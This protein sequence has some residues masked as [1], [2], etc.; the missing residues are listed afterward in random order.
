MLKEEDRNLNQHLKAHGGEPDPE[1]KKRV[2]GVYSDLIM[3]HVVNPHVEAYKKYRQSKEA[4]VAESLKKAGSTAS[5]LFVSSSLTS[6][7]S[8]TPAEVQQEQPAP[9]IVESVHTSEVSLLTTQLSSTSLPTAPSKPATP[10]NNNS[11]IKPPSV[12]VPLSGS[13]KATTVNTAHLNNIF[14]PTRRSPTSPLP[15]PNL[16]KDFNE[17]N[18]ADTATTGA[19]TNATPL[20]S[21]PSSTSILSTTSSILKLPP[22]KVRKQH[23]LIVTHGGFI[24]ELFSHLITDL[25]FPVLEPSRGFPRHTAVYRFSI[26][27]HTTKSMEFE[28]EGQVDKMNSLSHMAKIGKG[29]I[30]SN[31]NGAFGSGAPSVE[32][33]P[34]GTPQGSPWSSPKVVR[35]QL[36]L[37][38]VKEY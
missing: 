7:E 2:L 19:T 11:I 27:K 30:A 38:E 37:Q 32:P 10:S 25:Q 8:A 5:G 26:I 15:H 34:R 18:I 17:P 36:Y 22:K 23:I 33:S 14:S 20:P 6:T 24:Q 28:W 31:L 3:T 12:K 35:K 1:F 13:I 4:S 29:L 16:P 21:N 9:L